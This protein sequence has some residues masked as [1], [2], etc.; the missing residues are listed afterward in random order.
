[1]SK[2]GGVIGCLLYWRVGRHRLWPGWLVAAPY[3]G[4]VTS[5]LYGQAY[6]EATGQV[7]EPVLEPES[8]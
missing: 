6:L 5:H 8:T 3:A 1:V 7:P 2:A 4:W